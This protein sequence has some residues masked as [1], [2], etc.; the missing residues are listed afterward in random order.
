MRGKAPY[1]IILAEGIMFKRMNR[2][3][4]QS[5]L[6]ISGLLILLV[7]AFTMTMITNMVYQTFYSMA[8][9]KMERNISDCELYI[10]SA[11]TSTYNLAQ[12]EE[13]ISELDHPSG[14]SL[15]KKLD[16]LC[17]YS[18]KIDGAT[19]YSL[20]GSIYTSSKIGEVPPLE[21][22]AQ[23]EGIKD[24]FASDAE[25]F[26]SVRRKKVAKIYNDNSYPENY[27]II[28]CCH[29]VYKDEK[30]I[31]YL[32]A[33]ILPASLYQNFDYSSDNY[34]H[35]T[36]CFIASENDYLES[37]NN[38][39][40][41]NYYA[42]AKTKNLSGNLKYLF[43]QKESNLIGTTITCAFP[44]AGIAKTVCLIFG[45]LLILALVLLFIIRIIGRRFS[46]QVTNRLDNLLLKMTQD[47][48]K[49]MKT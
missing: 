33:D 46:N 2:H 7:I 21:E 23:D 15:T 38:L 42:E 36:V 9:E 14:N 11:L 40:L 30:V 47:K 35:G 25:S 37:N 34:F 24:F 32:F 27:G 31:G 48:N 4:Y 22:L 43:I 29:K 19:A 8:E 26:I 20:D 17:N 13:L 1:A 44:L 45:V 39:R 10:S 6:L 3:I 16:N 49:I 18:L 5:I 41:K 12:D 28:T